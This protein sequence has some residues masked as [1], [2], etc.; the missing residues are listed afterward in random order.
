MSRGILLNSFINLYPY[1]KKPTHTHEV[2]V[3]NMLWI[4][5]YQPELRLDILSLIFSRLVDLDANAPKEKIYEDSNNDEDVFTMDDCKSVKSESF[6]TKNLVAHTLDI[7]L[8]RIFNFIIVEC[9]NLD[10]GQ[11]NWDKTKSIYQTLIV[12]FEKIILPTYNIHHVQFI[13]FFLC[14]LKS[15]IT[16]GFITFLCKK[17]FSPNVA[18]VIRQTAVAYVA[19]LLARGAFISMR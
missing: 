11:L 7:C 15:T 10:T 6:R 19:S 12:V 4:L 8:D 14:S 18:S 3:H 17:V 16:D 5:D 9:H 1:I 2:Y 13:M